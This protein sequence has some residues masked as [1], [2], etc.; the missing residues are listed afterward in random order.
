MG[1]H[2]VDDFKKSVYLAEFAVVLLKD[3]SAFVH[4][5]EANE[6]IAGLYVGNYIVLC[7]VMSEILAA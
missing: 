2:I 4:D 1:K 7:S 3:F 6:K 5:A